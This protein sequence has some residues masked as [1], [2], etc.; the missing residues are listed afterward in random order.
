MAS[1]TICSSAGDSLRKLA[2][3][4]DI[5]AVPGPAEHKRRHRNLT[6]PRAQ[7]GAADLPQ[8]RDEGA[9]AAAAEILPGGLT[10]LGRP[11]EYIPASIRA[12]SASGVIRLI[13]RCSAN[14]RGGQA[15]PAESTSLAT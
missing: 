3:E 12:S 8:S 14:H 13:A 4:R 5:G 10:V 15:T 11:T 2:G 1:G 9:L 6:E 7:I